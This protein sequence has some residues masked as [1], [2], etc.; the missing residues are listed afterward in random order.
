MAILLE[1]ETAEMQSQARSD[2]TSDLH[3]RAIAAVLKRTAHAKT[4]QGE[5]TLR[6][7]QAMLESPAWKEHKLSSPEAMVMLI[8]SLGV[9]K[10]PTEA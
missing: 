3:Q 5:K 8:Q 4:D 1:L 6:F 7:L 9:T 10:Y 2:Y